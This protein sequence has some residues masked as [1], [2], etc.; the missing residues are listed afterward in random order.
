M[1][2]RVVGA[3]L[4]IQLLYSAACF[5]MEEAT[6]PNWS[7][8][9]AGRVRP[10]GTLCGINSIY[11]TLKIFQINTPYNEILQEVPPGIYG[12]T[13]DQIV[14]Y[15][16]TKSDLNVIPIKCDAISLYDSIKREEAKAIINIADHWCVI[17]SITDGYYEI[18]DFPKKYYMPMEEI[19]KYGEGYAIVVNKRTA[20]P[21]TIIA[22]VSLLVTCLFIAGFRNLPKYCYVQN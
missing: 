2:S 12:S 9:V 19:D 10:E 7:D 1:H 20:F 16:N 22:L 15:L 14:G 13:M 21:W 5:S 11:I 8:D 18:Y 3:V 6:A 4:I 17:M